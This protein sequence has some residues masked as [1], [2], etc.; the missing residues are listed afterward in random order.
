VID[1]LQAASAGAAARIAGWSHNQRSLAAFLFGVVGALAFAPVFFWPALMAGF[2]FLMWALDAEP[3]A[4]RAFWLGWWFGF[5]QCLAG[6]YWI[7]I[8]FQF[9][10]KMPA[11]LGW[12]AVG[13][14]AAFL[15][16]ST[17]LALWA[18]NRL[19]SSRASRVLALA[20]CWTAG[21]W[22]RGH[23]FTGF[24]WNM[25]GSVWL[26][27][28]VLA[29]TASLYGAYGLSLVTVAL[30]ATPAVLSRPATPQSKTAGLT[31]GLTAL[32]VVGYGLST[33]ALAPEDQPALDAQGRPVR[34][35]IV[36]ANIGQ[37][38]KWNPDAERMIL[39]RHLD[40]S[41]QAL[42]ER[43]AGIVIWPETAIQNDIETEISTRFLLH[44]ILDFDGL[45]LLGV[46]RLDRAAD[47]SFI[48]A[49]NSLAAL[50]GD[51]EITA[52]YDKAH[53]VPFGEYLPFRP[54]LERIGLA[55]L[56]PG[57]VDFVPG[58]GPRTL[59][60]AGLPSVGPLICYEAIFPSSV[61][62]RR[63]RPGWMLNISNDAWFGVS[64][65]PYQHL[66]QAQ[67]RSI[68]EGLPMVRSTP[69]GISAV[70]DANG[71]VVARLGHGEQAVLTA[72]LPA[73]ENATLY[74]RV[75]DWFYLTIG[76][77]AIAFAW[78]DRAQHLRKDRKIV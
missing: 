47:G 70:I 14:L 3:K 41:Q 56:A 65:G 19:W 4:G 62:D 35:H 76:V 31:A 5:G 26:G 34:V 42:D 73:A 44:R 46:V 32:A 58:P 48:S 63:D 54:L 23:L 40:M 18:A 61:I 20:V 11:L 36:Q 53:L 72:D 27:A 16:N 75:G 67:L 6:L 9:Q 57:A 64:S 2:I 17:G 50:N 45:L 24:P 55:R 59:A 60:L 22:L 10:A 69:T 1:R 13:G 12:I 51:G 28:P 37:D 43:G 71:R 66:A 7:A 29:Q 78:L 74:S 25:A 8:S 49:R 39:H 38:V 15:A 21:E 77:F 33:L 30:F 52:T 68:E